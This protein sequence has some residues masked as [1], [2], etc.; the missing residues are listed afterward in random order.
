MINIQRNFFIETILFETE[1][2]NH[3]SFK[4][5]PYKDN[6]VTSKSELEII[7]FDI[8]RVDNLQTLIKDLILIKGKTLFIPV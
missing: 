8:D 1:M 2:I 5:L 6:I 4:D 3:E 7:F